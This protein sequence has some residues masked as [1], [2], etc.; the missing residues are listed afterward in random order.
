MEF[1]GNTEGSPAEVYWDGHSFND[2]C[3]WLSRK[4]SREQRPTSGILKA[5]RKN[6]EQIIEEFQNLSGKESIRVFNDGAIFD[7][8]EVPEG[9]VIKFSGERYHM[10]PKMH[11]VFAKEPVH[12]KWGNE[13]GVILGFDYNGKRIVK[14]IELVYFDPADHAF[15]PNYRRVSGQFR[16]RPGYRAGYIFDAVQHIGQ[17]NHVRS[18]NHTLPLPLG[19]TQLLERINKIE[20][21]ALGKGVTQKVTDSVKDKQK[22][23]S[24]VSENMPS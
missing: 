21:M 11:N 20:L 19:R 7:A 1:K 9:S 8:K 3:R 4:Y 13:W 17:V 23:F 18:Q 16:L 14:I 22:V 10:Y 24:P 12:Q 2:N 5:M 15:D 6:A